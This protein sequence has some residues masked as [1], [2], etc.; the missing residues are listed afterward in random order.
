LGF[1][2]NLHLSVG[3]ILVEALGVRDDLDRD[4]LIVWNLLGLV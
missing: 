3:D 1:G 4:S 2:A